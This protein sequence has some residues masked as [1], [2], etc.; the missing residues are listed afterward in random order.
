MTSNGEK[1]S[2]TQ[3]K[4]AVHELQDLG[5]ELVE[6]KDDQLA[7]IDLP[8]ALRD[9]VMEARRIT[10]FGAKRRQLQYIG[11]IMR[12]IDAEPIRAALAELRAA[13]RG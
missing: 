13:R 2:K 1:P 4:R 5:A 6:L 10:R 11:K 12:R 8:E 7:A 9:A 3:R